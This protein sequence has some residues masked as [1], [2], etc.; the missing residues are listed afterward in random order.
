M[1]NIKLLNINA[2]I[3]FLSKKNIESSAVLHSK[4]K[5]FVLLAHAPFRLFI[6]SSVTKSNNVRLIKNGERED[7]SAKT[8]YYFLLTFHL[9][10]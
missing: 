4:R 8:K 5:V 2:C 3:H 7:M 10:K 1:H 9:K 6:I